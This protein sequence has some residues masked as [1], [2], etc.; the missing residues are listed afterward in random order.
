MAFYR[1]QK[2]I[3]VDNSGN[4]SYVMKINDIFTILDIVDDCLEI[5]CKPLNNLPGNRQWFK[6]RFR[7]I[8]E[9]KTDIG[10]AYDILNKHTIKEFS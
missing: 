7:P 9:R 6:N 10:F 2:V 4:A 3:C 5:N 8:V 1:G